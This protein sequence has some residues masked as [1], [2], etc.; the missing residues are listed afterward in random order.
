M[1]YDQAQLAA[2]YL[3]AWQVNREPLFEQTARGILD[4]VLRD[5]TSPDGAFFSAEDADSLIPGATEK[6]EGA[7]YVWTKAEIDAALGADA[8]LFNQVFGVVPEGNSPAGSDPHGELKGLNTLIRRLTGQD[9]AAPFQL[10]ATETSERLARCRAILL[11]RRSARPRPHL[12][13]KILASWNGLMISAFARAAML[14]GDDTYLQAALRAARFIRRSMYPDGRLLRSYRQGSGPQ[15]FADD[16]AA[17]AAAA[18]ALYEATE[19]IAWLQWSLELLATLDALFLDP[20]NGGYFSARAEDP[21]ILVR[22]KE[23]HDGAEPAASSL[24]ASTALRLALML[25]DA[26]LQAR[27]ME[28]IRAF[29]PQLR[30]NPI[31]MPAMLEA[32]L[33]SIT[34]P[35]QIIIAGPTSDAAPLARVARALAAPETVLLYA[36][37]GPAQSWLAERLPFMRTATSVDGKPAAYV[38]EN[39]TCR[40]PITDP[41]ELR[42]TLR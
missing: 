15:G 42:N 6:G 18:L 35:S 40:L 39:F 5:M 21:S 14:L 7:F 13:D 31:A 1:L 22:M 10:T 16:Y 29:A 9:A 27:A 26:P 41:V 8:P 17:M 2:T 38:C 32:F 12:D 33:F 4:Y 3:Q 20:L 19:D 25:D 11:E 37:A 34:P 28:T 36:D 23:D 30:A 24:A